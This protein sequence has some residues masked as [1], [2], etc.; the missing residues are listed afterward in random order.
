[1]LS[2]AVDPTPQSRLACQVQLNEQHDGLTL[3]VAK[4]QY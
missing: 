1:M 2:F 3:T 4:R